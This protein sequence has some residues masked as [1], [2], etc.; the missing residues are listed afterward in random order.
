MASQH[1]QPSLRSQIFESNKQI[2]NLSKA[3]SGLKECVKN[4]ESELSCFTNQELNN[5]RDLAEIKNLV[6]KLEQKLN[7]VINGIEYRY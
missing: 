1:S 4:S 2:L 3:F 6:Y 7:T 5:S